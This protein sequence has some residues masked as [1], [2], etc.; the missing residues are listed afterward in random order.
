MEPNLNYRSVTPEHY[1]PPKYRPE[2]E[3]VWVWC[4]PLIEKCLKYQNEYDI[5][6]IEQAIKNGKFMLWPHPT[7]KQSCFV[8]EIIEFPRYRAMNLIFCAGSWNELEE[9][10]INGIEPFARFSSVKKLFGGGRKG[11]IKALQRKNLGFK[12]EHIISK[13]L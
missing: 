4:K 6:D 9:I 7:S 3:N 8:T 1:P 5:I 13:E 11:W 12:K 2:E 10:L